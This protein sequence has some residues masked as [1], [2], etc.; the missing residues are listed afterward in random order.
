LHHPTDYLDRCEPKK[1]T[2][3]DLEEEEEKKTSNDQEKE[4][5]SRNTSHT[6]SPGMS[7][8]TKTTTTLGGGTKT[9]NSY[10]GS[11]HGDEN[12]QEYMI[13]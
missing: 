11:C 5:Y 4:T 3:E 9:Y 12:N 8:H 13:F 6:R 7:H 1:R 10:K 2:I